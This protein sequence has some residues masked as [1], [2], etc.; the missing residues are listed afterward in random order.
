M[1]AWG[2]EAQGLAPPAVFAAAGVDPAVLGQRGARIPIEPVVRTWEQIVRRFDDP[3]VGLRL[4]EA[5][6]F[7]TSD[8]LDYL[9][10]STG[11]VEQALRTVARYVAPLIISSDQMAL[12]MSG[13]EARM[14]IRTGGLPQMR[15]L[16]IG[17]FARRSRELF[18]PN[19]SLRS[20][21]FTH[22]RR[23]PSAAYD[24]LFQAPVHFDMPIN[25]A[26]F[27]REHMSVRMPD[28]DPGL[29]AILTAQADEFA[30]SMAPTPSP[31]SFVD[32]VEDAISR[33]LVEGD[34]TLTRVADH[35]R[36]SP[37]TV[38]RRLRQAGL[39]HRAVLDRMRL[40]LAGRALAGPRLSQREI[41]RALGYAGSGA[42]HRAF[43]RW[44]GMTPGEAR[45]R[46]DKD[47][48]RDG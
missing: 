47:E 18:G 9:V 15:E 13:N 36:L 29:N 2:M 19:W 42:F 22:S 11:T 37:R 21:S 4:A 14:R 23:G 41:A 26:V 25:E 46:K 38:Q 39:T 1:L 27:S 40:D 31:S 33:G 5:L 44:S 6:P 48:D 20:V 30:A 16:S 35:L 7:G 32:A 28:A 45:T 17:I 10:R 3:L 24:R 43:K 34:A 8:I 12:V